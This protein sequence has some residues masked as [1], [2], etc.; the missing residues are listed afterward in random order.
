M[1]SCWHEA[2]GKQDMEKATEVSRSWGS[3]LGCVAYLSACLGNLQ[4]V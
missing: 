4:S 2:S 1:A 3:G